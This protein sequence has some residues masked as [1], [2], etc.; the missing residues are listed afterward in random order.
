MTGTVLLRLQI[1]ISTCMCP[2]PN[3]YSGDHNHEALQEL[4]TDVLV[5]VL[6]HCPNAKI[7]FFGKKPNQCQCPL[8]VFLEQLPEERLA[9][10]FPEEFREGSNSFFSSFGYLP[11]SQHFLMQLNSIDQTKDLLQ[12]VAYVIALMLAILGE[13][14]MNK[15]LT[16]DK[17]GIRKIVLVLI[18]L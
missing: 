12:F 8:T 5:G 13:N 15:L 7:F 3:K 11:H 4:T 14:I 9:D 1:S 6:K 18:K 2:A 10:R 17:E 16:M